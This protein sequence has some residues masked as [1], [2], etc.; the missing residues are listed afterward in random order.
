M[1]ISIDALTFEAIIGVLD[2]ERTKPQTVI[3]DVKADYAYKDDEY[4]DYTQL[5]ALIE[6]TI[7]N[8]QF[9]LLE[10][11]IETL[12]KEIKQKFST[13]STLYLKIAKPTIVDNA[14]VALS[15]TLSFL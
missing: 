4:I 15:D 9:L 1:T 12:G 7:K 5:I 14:T 11:A 13:I 2:F 8:S 10:E 6:Q 3:V